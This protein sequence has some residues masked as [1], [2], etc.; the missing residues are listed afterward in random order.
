VGPPADPGAY[1]RRF[2]VQL[3]VPG[4]EPRIRARFER[5]FGLPWA[6][7]HAPT[8]ARRM[9]APLLVVHDRR[10]REV[11]WEDGAA[12]AAAWPGAELVTTAGLGHRRVLAD[13]AVVARAVDFL[14]AGRSALGVD[15]CATPGC[16]RPGVEAWGDGLLC[17]P[18]A[19]ERE[20][21]DPGA[22]WRRAVSHGVTVPTR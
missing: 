20:L 11:P 4:V 5:R 2:L 19:L 9:T 21:F 3:G 14:A 1:L 6:A 15:R 18:C 16:P 10:D 22:R 12:L 8:L 17:C 7:M 13:P